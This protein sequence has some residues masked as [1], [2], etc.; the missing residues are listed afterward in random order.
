ME[1]DLL[2]QGGLLLAD[3]PAGFTSHDAVMIIRNKLKIRRIGHTGT[4]DP[5]AT[6]LLIMLI[7]PATKLQNQY[8]QAT[9]VYTGTIS[10]G[11]ET[12]TWD[13]EGKVLADKPVPPLT[14]DD[15]K[16]ALTA[17]TGEIVQIVPPFSA[18]KVGGVPMHKLARKGIPTKE[19]MKKVTISSWTNLEWNAPELSFRV[20]CTTGTY[21]RALAH[22]L[23]QNLGCGAHLKVLRRLQA[24][25]FGVDGALDIAAA[26]N[27]TAEEISRY[28][29]PLPCSLP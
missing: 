14:L 13:A 8:Q 16:K 24:G 2:K 25:A 11:R 28:I 19:V 17:F 29:Q 6:G 26:K 12:D 21:V 20:E 1:L 3:K 18:V 5:A 23:G 7:G 9:K 27:M 4:L 10:F 22:M 15:L